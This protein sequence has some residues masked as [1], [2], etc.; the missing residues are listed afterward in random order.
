VRN[1]AQKVGQAT[2]EINSNISEMTSLVA[3]TEQ[4][5]STILENVQEAESFLTR[6][7]DQF[8][9]MVASFEQMSQQLATIST[10]IEQLSATNRLTHHNVTK[11]A[12]LSHSV[13][14]DMVQ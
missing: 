4:G 1:L 6:T 8:I 11:I 10:A 13:K 9:N 14:E 7:S 12:E 2:Q 5:S 3:K